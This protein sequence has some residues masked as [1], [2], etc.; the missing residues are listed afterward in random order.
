MF[1]PVHACG[2]V[3]VCISAEPIHGEVI[4]GWP[5][6]GGKVGEH[7]CTLQQE[8]VGTNWPAHRGLKGE[9]NVLEPNNQHVHVFSGWPSSAGAAGQSRTMGVRAAWELW[10]VRHT[11]RDT[12]HPSAGR[13][14]SQAH[15]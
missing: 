9:I 15:R 4:A 10:V 12:Q 13:W 8:S 1:V 6:C 2:L 7:G 5:H 3:P 14:N 11:S